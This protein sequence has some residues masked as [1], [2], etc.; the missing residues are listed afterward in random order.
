[1][2]RRLSGYYRFEGQ[3]TVDV[4]NMMYDLLVL[5]I[6]HFMPSQKLMSKTRDGAHAPRKHDKSPTPHQRIMADESILQEVKN[7]LT[8]TFKELDV[9]ELRHQIACLQDELKKLAVFYG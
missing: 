2:V 8:A 7:G 3:H 6:N 1:V 9:Y 4:L 5:Y